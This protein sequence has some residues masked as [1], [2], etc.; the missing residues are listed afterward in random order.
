MQFRLSDQR[1]CS[2][3]TSKTAIQRVIATVYPK[4]GEGTKLNLEEFSPTERNRGLIQLSSGPCREPCLVLKLED[5]KKKTGR[6]PQCSI[7]LNYFKHSKILVTEVV[8][9]SRATMCS[10]C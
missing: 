5:R 1:S 8:T 9:K 3:D 6:V 7:I 10:S 2:F 4:G